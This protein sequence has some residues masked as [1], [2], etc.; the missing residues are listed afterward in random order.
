MCILS[1]IYEEENG[2]GDT[3]HFTAWGTLYFPIL[4]LVCKGIL[5][6]MINV[7][8]TVQYSQGLG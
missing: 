7:C 5:V 8:H 6:V 2:Y 3:G 1:F 4:V